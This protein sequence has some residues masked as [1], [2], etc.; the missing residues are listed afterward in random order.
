MKKKTVAVPESSTTVVNS[1]LKYQ[2]M[3]FTKEL[4][5]WS[6]E[7][8]KIESKRKKYLTRDEEPLC[9]HNIRARRSHKKTTVDITEMNKMRDI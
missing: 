9:T 7:M 4:Y 2:E 8:T 1:S 3:N 5:N 6:Y